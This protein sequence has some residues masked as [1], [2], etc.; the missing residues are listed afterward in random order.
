MFHG[1][2]VGGKMKLN[3]A[4]AELRKEEKRKFEQSIDLVVNLRGIDVKREGINVVLSIPHKIKTKRVCGFLNEK[5]PHVDTVKELDFSKYKDKK[6]LKNLVKNYDFFIAS[7]NLMPKVATAFGKV[8]GPIGKMPSPQLGILPQE[9]EAA[10]KS[11]LEKIDKSIKIR[12]KEASIKV[13][14]AKESMSDMEVS[15]NIESVYKGIESALPKKKD[16]IK[17]VL[18]KTTMG[19]PIRVEM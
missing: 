17:N 7:A 4:I 5:S 11:L 10:I 15:E 2:N 18:I 14:V 12:M 16:N 3:E 1:R 8:L 6:P 13:V 19:K 9:N